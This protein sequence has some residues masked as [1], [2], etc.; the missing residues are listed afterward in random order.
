MTTERPTPGE[1]HSLADS[2]ERDTFVVNDSATRSNLHLYAAALRS[3]AEEAERA[4]EMRAILADVM[5]DVESWGVD[6]YQF[7][8]CHRARAI[9]GGTD[10][11]R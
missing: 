10:D 2:A 1:L 7:E 11:R 3:A 9:L 8:S 4:Q 6:E 5:A